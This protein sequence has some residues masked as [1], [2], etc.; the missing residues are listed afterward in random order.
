MPF[1]FRSGRVSLDLTA[2][3]VGR[4]REPVEQLS[5]PSDL[6]R[7]FAAAGIE[8]APRR[9]TP[10]DLRLARELREAVYAL[11]Q[12]ARRRAVLPSREIEVAPSRASLPP[13]ENEAAG[14]RAALP[15][16]EIEA[17]GGRAGLPVDDLETVNAVAAHPPP[18]PRLGADSAVAWHA[19]EPA[20]AALAHIARDAIALLSGPL[21]ERI[22]ECAGEDC[23]LL[24]VD[25]SRP[26]RRR[27]CADDACGNRQH[28]R[29]HRARQRPAT[30]R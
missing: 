28:V 10:A 4:Y 30:P 26:G 16:D 5:E 2:T 27:W 13:R 25:T 17:P 21:A 24:F 15:P 9:V 7:W 3:V 14:G 1:R 6:A 8:P 11:A 18:E 23:A 20:R 12:A 19:G 22:G 29:D